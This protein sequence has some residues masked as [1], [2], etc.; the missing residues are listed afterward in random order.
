MKVEQVRKPVSILV[1]GFPQDSQLWGAWEVLRNHGVSP[2]F[3]GAIVKEAEDGGRPDYA[4]L[5]SVLVPRGRQGEIETLLREQGA[6]VVGEPV[7]LGLNYTAIPHPGAVVDHDFKLPAGREYPTTLWPPALSGYRVRPRML[8]KEE[9]IGSFN[10]VELGYSLEEALIEA[11][12]CL[13]CPEPPC[14]G[15]CPAHNIPA[16]IRSLRERNFERGV[17]ALRKTTNFPG[18]C[19]RVCDKTR[20]CEGACVLVKEGGDAV[21]IGL[22]ERFLADWELGEGLR[23]SQAKAKAPATGKRV[24]IVGSGPSGLA[25]AS[26]LGLKGH[27]VTVYE[28]RPVLGGALAWGIPPFRLPPSVV[29]A[30]IDYL[31]ALGVDFKVGVKVGADLTID[32]LFAQGYKAIFIGSGASVS[33]NLGI[34]GEELEGIYTAAEFLSRAK[35][36]LV[37]KLP[38]YRPPTVGAR[39]VV[40][41]GGNTA[42]DVAET[43]LRLQ[44]DG[45][46]EVLEQDRSAMDVAETALRLGFRETTVVYRR[47]E[48][49][50]PARCEEVESAKEAGTRFRFLTSP[51][52]FIGDKMGRVVAM[53]CIEMGLGPIDRS[54]RRQPIPKP[55]T[56]FTIPVDTVVIAVGYETDL[57]LAQNTPGIKVDRGLITV[58]RE[59]G[60][61]SRPGV[62]AGG[63]IITGADTV[64][65]AMVAGKRAATDIDRYL[66]EA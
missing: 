64:V 19:G 51:S 66:R 10:E 49:E 31:S 41:G 58:D 8:E 28:A 42:M 43:V 65:R 17:G 1:A 63:D 26:D 55:G 6:T 45:I 22:L 60:R 46:R 36:A 50:M 33:I 30:E 11:G 23:L 16:F 32:D 21:A 57:T 59:T 37:Y 47:S 4:N 2:D 54:G 52:R 48:A 39:L 12:R 34:P 5:L 53:E 25:A 14:V 29:Q 9:R 44:Y 13:G 35:L 62:W 40:I 38:F 18:I 7:E 24:A 3:I 20:Q 56:E 27:E 61:T 15:G